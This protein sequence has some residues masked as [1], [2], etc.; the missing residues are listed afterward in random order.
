MGCH[1]SGF[2]GISWLKELAR[3]VT[4]PSTSKRAYSEFQKSS[5]ARWGK[6]IFLPLKASDENV[7][8]GVRVPFTTEQ[9]EM[10]EQIQCLAMLL[11]DSLD[12]TALEELSGKRVQEGRRIDL[13]ADL[14]AGL[15]MVKE[16]Q[17]SFVRALRAVQTLRSTGAAHRKGDKYDKALRKLEF[18]GKNGQQ[19]LSALL[20]DLTSGLEAAKRAI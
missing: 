2:N 19:I 18:V 8:A 20:Q 9:R 10:D 7:L 17:V 1:L 3:E 4:S 12:Q 13:F 15:G 14:L 6:T 11:T 16:A 5:V